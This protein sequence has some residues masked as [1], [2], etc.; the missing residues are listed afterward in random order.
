MTLLVGV[1]EAVFLATVRDGDLVG[2]L[3]GTAHLGLLVTAWCWVWVW[4]IKSLVAGRLGNVAVRTIDG[5]E[6]VV[7][8]SL[9][10]VVGLV[11]WVVSLEEDGVLW[12]NDWVGDLEVEVGFRASSGNAGWGS[13]AI[14]TLKCWV[15]A[16][17][18]ARLQSQEEFVQIL[19]SVI[20]SK[21]LK[22]TE[23]VARHSSC[24]VGVVVHCLDA[25]WSNDGVTERQCRRGK[26]LCDRLWHS[27][28]KRGH[29]AALAKSKGSLLEFLCLWRARGNEVDT[30]SHVVDVLGDGFVHM[31]LV[32]ADGHLASGL[33]LEEVV[34][35][36]EK[37]LGFPCL[38]INCHPLLV[39]A[40]GDAVSLNTSPVQPAANSLDSIGAWSKQIMDLLGTVVLAE[41]WR[42]GVR[43]FGYDQL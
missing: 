12:P 27:L 9:V 30:W 11:D 15:G 23:L 22:D 1:G 41:L 3:V 5:V 37:R 4:W 17:W 14:D 29:R 6:E 21:I 26:D 35:G 25:V 19:L 43:T 16:D 13:T 2:W 24:R 7:Q 33:V 42:V 36:V 40:L 31:V 34:L 18:N 39:D 32:T 20:V 28:E 10:D 38:K 8:E